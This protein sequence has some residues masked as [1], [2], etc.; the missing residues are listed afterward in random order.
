MTSLRFPASK[1]IRRSILLALIAVMTAISFAQANPKPSAQPTPSEIDAR[2][3]FQNAKFGLFIHWGI[4]SELGAGEWVMETHKIP[5]RDYEKLAPQFYPVR[6]DPVTWVALAKA[7]GMKYITITSRH[8]D[9]F[10]MFKTKQTDWNIVDRT[11]YAKDP[12]RMLADECH[13]EG[14][15]LFFYYSQLDWHHPDYFPRGNTGK[16]AGRPESGDWNR[17]IDFMNAQLTELLTNY[18]EIGG[19]WFDGMW[20]KPD[21]DWQLERTY[22]LIHTLQ[23]QALIIPNHHKKPLPGEDVQTFE[24]DLPGENKSGF[25]ATAEIGN[26]P[27]ETSDTVNQSWGFNL[28]DD[29]YKTPKQLIEYLVNAAGRNANLLLNVGPM[30]NGEFPPEAIANLQQVGKWLQRNGESI[31][32]TRGGPMA[33]QPWGVTTTKGDRIF[34]HILKEIAQIDLP[35]LSHV[36]SAYELYGHRKIDFHASA[37]GI[38]LMIP[39]STSNEGLDRVVVLDLNSGH[40]CR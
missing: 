13:R 8:H 31:Y 18:G 21:A 34:V 22:R 1:V 23:P 40:R 29:A 11:P 38:K 14:I 36:C 3:W 16:S 7:A 9:G 28:T 37:A 26:L 39:P 17:Y 15:K 19:I 12:L 5:I 20:D 10:S 6:Y 24:R 4:Y 27:F 33:P 30:P 25:S 2:R 35:G 32:G